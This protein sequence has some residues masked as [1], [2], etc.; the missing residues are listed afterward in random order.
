MANDRVASALPRLATGVPGLDVVLGGG[1]VAGRTIVVAGPPGTGKTTLGNQMA[2]AHGAAGGASVVGTLIA[3]PHDLMLADLRGFSFFDPAL[4]GNRVQH[5]S[6]LAA[7]EGGG[8]D[9]VIAAV[10]QIVRD[11]DVSLLIVDGTSVVEDL[12][13]SPF[14]LQ[15]FAQRLQA[16]AALLGCTTVLLTGH[17]DEDLPRFGAQ[18]DGVIALVNERSDARRLR[19]L[20]V[21]KLRG[22]RHLSGVHEFEIG[23]D[24]LA[25]HPRLEA[26]VGNRRPQQ[27]PGQ[28]LGTGVVGLDG[29][30]GG[31]LM[32]LSSTLL[33]GTPGAGKTLLGL[34]FLTEGARRGERGLMVGFH[35]MAPDLASTAA[36]V[37]LDLGDHIAAGLVRVL[38]EAPLEVS[39][40][41]WA[42]R[43]LAAVEEHR[44]NRVFLDALTDIQRI[45]ASPVRSPTF[46]TALANEL[47]A[48]GATTLIAAEIDTLADDRLPIPVPAA[49]A[50]MDNG[51]LLRQ[52]ELRSEVRRLVSV[53]KARQAEHDPAIREFV[54]GS[55]GIVVAE[56]FARASS[57]L[58]TGRAAPQEPP[59]A[60]QGP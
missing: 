35:E 11:G 7:L 21:L 1:L 24:G 9:G 59:G 6:L 40:D 17:G 15:R 58:L 47:R 51:I 54:I 22:A 19:Q 46:T 42:W 29:M 37:G 44:P 14:D 48:L 36:G 45:I 31:G 16:Q 53:L 32:P 26:V 50:T 43:L 25:V 3:E 5:L 2:F 23:D 27:D 57:G 60:V 33:M 38:W 13:P 34:S 49:S 20:E 10:R 56:P 8:L 39:P 41:A 28:G 18:V 55:G 30:L 4:V 52:I 12:A